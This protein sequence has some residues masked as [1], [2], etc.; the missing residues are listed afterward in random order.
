MNS[1]SEKEDKGEI[2]N[3]IYK[4]LMFDKTPQDL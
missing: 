3:A 2:K 1:D 4:K